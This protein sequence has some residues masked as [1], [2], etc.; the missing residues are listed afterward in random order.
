[1]SSSFPLLNP[2]NFFSNYSPHP[3]YQSDVFDI[4]YTQVTT[5]TKQERLLI[6]LGIDQIEYPSLY[7]DLKELSSFF[8]KPIFRQRNNILKI[9][10][11]VFGLINNVIECWIICEFPSTLFLTD[12]VNYERLHM[13][14][15]HFM[16]SDFLNI[17]NDISFLTISSTVNIYTVML[18]RE[19]AS[20]Y[21]KAVL[22][23]LAFVLPLYYKNINEITEPPFISIGSLMELVNYIPY[24]QPIITAF[25]SNQQLEYIMQLKETNEVLNFTTIPMTSIQE[26]QPISLVGS[27]G[28]GHVIKAKT[29]TDSIVAIKESGKKY[30]ETLKREAVIMRICDHPNVVKFINFG[31]C[32]RFICI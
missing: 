13:D 19:P 8:F 17:A 23:P 5:K 31:N 3:F 27:G 29:S 22:S 16:F 9:D 25:A 11:T 7:N 26:Y 14:E 2:S 15:I 28:Y 30:I 18:K 20:P 1:M 6:R 10:R 21:P 12:Y 4:S 32:T 24:L